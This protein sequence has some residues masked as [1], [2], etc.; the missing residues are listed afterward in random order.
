MYSTGH[1]PSRIAAVISDDWIFHIA[2]QLF[3]LHIHTVLDFLLISYFG[4]FFP[5][6]FFCIAYSSPLLPRSMSCVEA[7]LLNIV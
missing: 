4:F 3:Q 1:I 5:F 6:P 2:F 7:G